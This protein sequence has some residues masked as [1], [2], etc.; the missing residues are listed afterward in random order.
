MENELTADEMALFYQL[1]L[2]DKERRIYVMKII[3]KML[4]STD[5]AKTL[6]SII[7]L[8]ILTSCLSFEDIEI[9]VNHNVAESKTEIVEIEFDQSNG[10]VWSTL[11]PQFQAISE[12]AY[13]E[14]I[15]TDGINMFIEMKNLKL[16]RTH[17]LFVDNCDASWYSVYYYDLKKVEFFLQE[18]C[19]N[20]TFGNTNSIIFTIEIER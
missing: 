12:S 14:Q 1:K 18:Y 11:E 2:M 19:Y 6:L 13:F 15:G 10:K 16:V 3:N 5:Y 9:N 7:I 4:K 20:S 17:S 8:I